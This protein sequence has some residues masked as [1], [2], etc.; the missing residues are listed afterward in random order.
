MEIP[1][2]EFCEELLLDIIGYEICCG[3]LS[4]EMRYL[5]QRH[6]EQCGKCQHSYLK[7]LHAIQGDRVARS[8]G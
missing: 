7:F 8:Y 2:R 5:F 6:L 3:R 1:D 4:S